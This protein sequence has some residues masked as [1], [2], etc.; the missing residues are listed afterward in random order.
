M[1]SAEPKAR[2]DNTYRD[3]DLPDIIV[4]KPNLIIVLLYIVLTK[5]MTKT[6]SRG[7]ELTLLLEFMHCVHNLQISHLSASR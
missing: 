3:L 5:I 4:Q 7:T 1:L 6:L 2:A